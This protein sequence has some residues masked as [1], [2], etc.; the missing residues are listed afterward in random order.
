MANILVT[1]GAGYI[2][3]HIVQLLQ[4]SR[5]SVV[6]VDNLV[7]GFA[8]AISECPLIEADVGD[9]TLIL[10]LL[11][12]YKIDAVMHLA[13]STEVAES[14]VNPQQYY[15]N[16]FA[17]TV[18]LLE[19]CQQANIQNFIFS[20]TAAVYGDVRE[21]PVTETHPCT[22]INP[23][24]RSKWFA[25]QALVDVSRISKLRFVTLR[26][27]NV[28]G[29]NPDGSNGDRRANSPALIN[30]AARTALGLQDSM[31]IF[32]VDW[33]TADGSAIRDFIHVMDIAD[34]HI[35]ALDYLL[36][37]KPSITL[38]CGYGQE[39]SVW[40][41]LKAAEK[42]T[43]KHFTI[44]QV[45]RQPGSPKSVI[46]DNKKIKQILSWQ[47]SY[48]DLELIIGSTIHWTEKQSMRT[49]GR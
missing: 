20:S 31:E 44:K 25:E 49:E 18:A 27:F 43:S 42:I 14:M 16:N 30:V 11:N 3:S 29:A 39:F 21:N 32:G 36:E 4:K 48:N 19:C 7:T 22:P 24:G 40:Q 17:N 12:K 45:P 6:V 38:N 28:A 5:H 10:E 15:Q 2:G 8:D 34:A 13:A 26:Y 33:D 41:V 37:G 23:Y 47:P 1:G 35:C 46:A 9:Q